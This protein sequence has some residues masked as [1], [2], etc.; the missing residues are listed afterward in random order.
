[1]YRS[2]KH[3]L[4]T[5]L[6]Q[7]DVAQFLAVYWL[8]QWREV[9]LIVEQND[10]GIHLQNTVQTVTVWLCVTRQNLMKSHLC[11]YFCLFWP[12]VVWSWPWLSTLWPH[13][14]QNCRT[15]NKTYNQIQ[16]IIIQRHTMTKWPQSRILAIFGHNVVTLTFDLKI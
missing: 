8:A 14:A 10:D 16:I 3:L 12:Y 15:T 9:D 1:M 5:M 4:L 2:S 6:Q 11:I 7:F 13:F